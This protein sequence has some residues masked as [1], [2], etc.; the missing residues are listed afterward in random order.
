[1]HQYQDGF[2]IITHEDLDG[3]DESYVSKT[4]W[5]VVLK[6]YSVIDGYEDMED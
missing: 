2:K 5:V 4:N 1:M 3:M 6:W